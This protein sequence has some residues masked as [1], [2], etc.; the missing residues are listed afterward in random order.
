MQALAYLGLDPNR[1]GITLVESK[2]G[3]LGVVRALESGEIDAAGVDPLQSAQLRAKGFFCC[4]IRR[5]RIFPVFRMALQSLA[6]T[7]VSAQTWSKR[8]S[9]EWL[10][11]SPLAFRHRTKQLS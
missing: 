2:T 10:K 8:S 9:P 1:D 7:F 6:P 3:P 4:S 11:E 5:Q